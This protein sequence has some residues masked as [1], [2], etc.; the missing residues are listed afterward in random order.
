MKLRINIS[1]KQLLDL[2]H[3]LPKSEIERLTITLQS[4]I[5]SYQTSNSLEKMILNAPTWSNEILREFNNART[6]IKQSRMA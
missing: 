4:E 6:H 1:Y 3:Q 5:E 2:I